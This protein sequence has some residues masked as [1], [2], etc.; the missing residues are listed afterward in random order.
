MRHII[1]VPTICEGV[2]IIVPDVLVTRCLH[3]DCSAST[4]SIFIIDLHIYRLDDLCY[5]HHTHLQSCWRKNLGLELWNGRPSRSWAC[6]LFVLRVVRCVTFFVAAVRIHYDFSYLILRQQTSLSY[7]RNFTLHWGE[8]K[9][10]SKISTERIRNFCKI[11]GGNVS[12]P[13]LRTVTQLPVRNNIRFYHAN[14]PFHVL[15]AR[16]H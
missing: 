11:L 7:M 4:L 15:N 9:R 8:M 1:L 5:Q 2:V 12:F 6:L 13:Y 10:N 14:I 3:T 16:L